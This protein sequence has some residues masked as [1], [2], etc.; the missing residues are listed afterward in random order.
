VDRKRKGPTSAVNL[1]RFTRLTRMSRD[2]HLD[3]VPGFVEFHLL[4]GPE[5]RPYVMLRAP[6]GK[7][8]R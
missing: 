7:T 1:D 8:V 5:L 3:K 2:S 6:A 4:K